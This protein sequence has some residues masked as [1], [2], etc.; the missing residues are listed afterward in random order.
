MKTIPTAAGENP[1]FPARPAREAENA[2][3]A[4]EPAIYT[5]LP[6]KNLTETATAATLPAS[7]RPAKEAEPAD[8]AIRVSDCWKFCQQS[9]SAANF[10][11]WSLQC[12]IGSD[13]FKVPEVVSFFDSLSDADFPFP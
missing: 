13:R 3:P 10:Y 8:C 9:V 11:I 12:K 4:A 6:P 1:P 5:A 2:K 7:A